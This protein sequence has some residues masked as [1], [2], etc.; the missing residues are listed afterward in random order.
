VRRIASAAGIA[1]LLLGAAACTSST[2]AAPSSDRTVTRT[3]THTTTPPPH[4][5]PVQTG[6]T[7]TAQAKACPLLATQRAA[8][9]VGMRLARI[10]VLRSGGAVIGCNF[11]ALQGSP[12]ATSEH[13]PGPNQPVISI[14]TSRYPD[15]TAA[16]NAMVLRARAGTEASQVGLPHGVTG[17]VFRTDLDPHDAGRDWACAF[18]RGAALTVV[19][20]AVTRTSVNAV[21]LAGRLT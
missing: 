7:T 8:D 15:A 21:T 2:P 17:V 12:L 10:T 13:L 19:R 14:V 11:Y 5:V 1:G 4:P 6:P 18:T 20:T 16:H 3:E 9:D